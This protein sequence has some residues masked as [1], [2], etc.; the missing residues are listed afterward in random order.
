MDVSGQFRGCFFHCSLIRAMLNDFLKCRKR[1]FERIRV[2][3]APPSTAGGPSGP[4]P[5]LQND[6]RQALC[7]IQPRTAGRGVT[8]AMRRTSGKEDVQES[9]FTS[10]IFSTGILSGSDPASSSTASRFGK[11]SV[12]D[13]RK[14]LGTVRMGWGDDRV[15]GR[16]RA[17]LRSIELA[18][19]R[20]HAWPMSRSAP[21]QA[22]PLAGLFPQSNA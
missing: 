7:L 19:Q 21:S 11:T 12:S 2:I 17:D 9:P 14:E 15:S 6:L 20:M 4:S 3:L 22:P 10:L 5:R 1:Y 8:V 16:P 13:L 18:L